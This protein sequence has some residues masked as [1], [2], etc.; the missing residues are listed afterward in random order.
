M[1]APPATTFRHSESFDRVLFPTRSHSCRN[2]TFACGSPLLLSSRCSL[3]VSSCR[4]V[5]RSPASAAVRDRQAASRPRPHRAHR[6][7]SAACPE[8]SR[9]FQGL[10]VRRRASRAFRECP[11][12]SRACPDRAASV[13]VRRASQGLPAVF[14]E[15]EVVRR[16]SREL[17]AAFPESVASAG[18]G[19]VGSVGWVAPASV[20]W[21]ASARAP[22]PC[23]RAPSAG[24]NSGAGRSIRVSRAARGAA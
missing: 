9:E 21:A 3:S 23:G 5:R 10:R 8:G 15:S 17:R 18:P 4:P 7:A 6:L 1:P 12:G 20:G 11:A 19:S 13:A 22:R 24:L 14:R 2:H 16:A